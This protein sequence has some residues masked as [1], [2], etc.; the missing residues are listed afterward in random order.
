M[1]DNPVPDESS[2]NLRI[3]HTSAV[4][5]P[6]NQSPDNTLGT[7]INTSMSS[8]FAPRICCIHSD[9]FHPTDEDIKTIPIEFKLD[10]C[11]LTTSIGIEDGRNTISDHSFHKSIQTEPDIHG[12]GQSP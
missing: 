3:P 8:M 4:L 10:R 1:S 6:L 11:I 12:G 9:L 2:H 5:V 7:P